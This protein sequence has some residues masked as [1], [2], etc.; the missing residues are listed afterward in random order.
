MHPEDEPHKQMQDLLKKWK[1]SVEK[2]RLSRER[3]KGE[4]DAFIKIIK[5]MNIPETYKLILDTA[6]TFMEKVVKNEFDIKDIEIRHYESTDLIQRQIDVL[7][8]K[9]AG[10]DK[11][12]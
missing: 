7:S 11:R 8:D 3:A 4:L 6:V 10:L 2:D 12:R 5:T 9:V 1:D